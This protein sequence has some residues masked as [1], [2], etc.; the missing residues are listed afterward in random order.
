M[1]HLYACYGFYVF[2]PF[3]LQKAILK[4]QQSLI[5][6]LWGFLSYQ[7]RTVLPEVTR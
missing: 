7:G 4:V 6:N 5:N 2:F 3:V 1:H